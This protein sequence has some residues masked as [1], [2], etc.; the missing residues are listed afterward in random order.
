MRSGRKGLAFQAGYHDAASP[1][2]DG[3]TVREKETAISPGNKPGRYMAVTRNGYLFLCSIALLLVISGSVVAISPSPS[4]FTSGIRFAGLTGF[5]LLAVAA[6]MTPWSRE[7]YRNFGTSFGK[8]HHIFAVSGLILITLHPVFLAIRLMTAS[9]FLPRFS[10]IQEFLFL[11]GRPSLILLYIAL[12]G[13]LLRR[14][15]PMYW[16]FF[17]ALIWVALMLGIIHGDLIGTDMKNPVIFILFNG[18]AVIAVGAF[19]LKRLK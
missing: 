17:H 18:L 4:L 9:V 3:D 7:I 11:A 8:F 10:S 6:I 15:M 2:Q 1:G 14:Y 13:I 5:V 19:I 16:R 12:A